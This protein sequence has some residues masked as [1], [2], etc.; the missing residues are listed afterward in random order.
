MHGALHTANQQPD[1]GHC[2]VGAVIG[3]WNVGSSTENVL[4]LSLEMELGFFF[5]R[6]AAS[7]SQLPLFRHYRVAGL[8][9]CDHYTSLLLVN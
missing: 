4:A 8:E 1:A 3:R 9:L 5:H 6:F 7:A 2:H